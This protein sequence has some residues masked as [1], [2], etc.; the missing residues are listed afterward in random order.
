MLPIL[1]EIGPI[2]I[3]S[4]GL[5]LTLGYLAATFILWREGKRQG[6]NDEKLLDL[7]V[8][9]LVAALVGGRIYFVL[10]N[11][12]LFS[13]E[14]INSL[15]FWQGGFAYHGALIAVLIIGAYF[16]RRWKWSFFQ[17]A[18][19]SS[20]SAS[21]A[22]VLGKIGAFLAGL[23]FGKETSLPWGVNFPGLI[24]LRHPVQLYEAAGYFIILVFLLILY[25]RNLTSS[26][27]KSGKVFFSFLISTSL[28]RLGLEVFRADSLVVFSIPLALLTSL[29]IALISIVA[30]YYFHIREFRDDAKR[31]LTG[32]L[33]FNTRFLRKIGF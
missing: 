13:E 22:L 20:L 26:E 19:I 15:A 28:V 14:P 9:S 7:S 5:F 4:F 3:Y 17:V 25:Y 1:F 30:L 33:G 29:I 27:M 11:P 16:V 6:Y 23:D 18:D 8:I 2:T 24:G 10:L 31:I 12:S 32:L 21:A